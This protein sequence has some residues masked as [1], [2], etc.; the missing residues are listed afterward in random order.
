[1]RA[2]THPYVYCKNTPGQ[3]MKGRS[4]DDV[5]GVY[6]G[7]STASDVFLISST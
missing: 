7:L 1:M 2:T 6:C 5:Q 3:D 4:Q